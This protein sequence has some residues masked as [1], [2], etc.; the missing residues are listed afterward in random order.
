MTFK[1]S[2]DEFRCIA[3]LK[4][5]ASK[6]E[7]RSKDQPFS[8]DAVGAKYLRKAAENIE[9]GKHRKAEFDA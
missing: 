9:A 7:G 1:P 5:W 4:E 8:G 2:I 3:A 6:L